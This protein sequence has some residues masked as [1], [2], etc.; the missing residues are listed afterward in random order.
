[1]ARVTVED[2]LKNVDNRFILVHMAN[3]RTRQLFKGVKPLIEAEDNREIVKALREVAALKVN[4]DEDS[5]AALR[6]GGYMTVAEEQ[7]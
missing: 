3:K 6:Q 7:D 2:C 1:M 5:D 4:L